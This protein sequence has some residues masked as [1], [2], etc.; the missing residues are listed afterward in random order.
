MDSDDGISVAI[1][2][3]T[4][5]GERFFSGWGKGGRVQTAWSLAGAKLFL[6]C[7]REDLD[8][9][10]SKLKAKNKKFSLVKVGEQ[11]SGVNQ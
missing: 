8:L 9:V 10:I 5:S 11:E 1:K 6:V 2:I 7:I 4:R 3:K